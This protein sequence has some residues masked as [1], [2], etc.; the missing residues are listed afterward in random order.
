[1]VF[2]KNGVHEEEVNMKHPLDFENPNALHFICK[3]DKALYG[4]K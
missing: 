2:M 1:M 4:L 3:L